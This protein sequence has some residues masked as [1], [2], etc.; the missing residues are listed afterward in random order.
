[1]STHEPAKP[2]SLL[3]WLGI[4]IL[5]A[6]IFMGVLYLAIEN[7]PD[8]MPAQQKKAAGIDVHAKHANSDQAV[9]HEQHSATEHAEAVNNENTTHESH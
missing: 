4:P 9:D 7:E 3:K 1:M 5:V 6:T 8:Y 2:P